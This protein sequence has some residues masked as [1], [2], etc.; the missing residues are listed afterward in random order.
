MTSVQTQDYSQLLGLTHVGQSHG[1]K[2]TIPAPKLG[3]NDDEDALQLNV[4]LVK[5]TE[6]MD[7]K[8]WCKDVDRTTIPVSSVF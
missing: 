2:V 1:V 3:N 4:S 5:S 7:K 6:E 8:K